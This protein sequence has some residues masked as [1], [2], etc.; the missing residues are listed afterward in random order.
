[1]TKAH[2]ILFLFLLAVVWSCDSERVFEDDQSFE[3]HSWHMDNM[4]Q[5]SFEIDDTSAMNIYFKMRND[6]EYPFQNIYLTYYLLDEAGEEIASELVNIEL[7]DEITGKPQGK[8]NSIY[9]SSEAILTSYSFPKAGEYTLKFAQYMR[10]ESLAGVHS[11][12]VRIEE[13]L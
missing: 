9:Q 7:F 11:V 12:G 13:G 10:S 2:K 5:F 3:N 6:L 8:G 4:P 1:M